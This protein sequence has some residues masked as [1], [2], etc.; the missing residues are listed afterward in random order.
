MKK[1]YTKNDSLGGFTFRNGN[2]VIAWISVLVALVTFVGWPIRNIALVCWIYGS[3]YYFVYGIRVVPGKPVRFSNGELVPKFA[4]VITGLGAIFI[5]FIVF[6]GA[7]MLMIK[8][9]NQMN[10]DK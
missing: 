3:K 5:T 1:P 7:S 9:V 8:I 2:I 10:N 4:D 6:F